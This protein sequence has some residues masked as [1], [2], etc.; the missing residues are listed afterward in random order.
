M[1]TVLMPIVNRKQSFK[2]ILEVF[3]GCE[4][5][6]KISLVILTEKNNKILEEITEDSPS[7]FPIFVDVFSVGTSEEAMISSAIKNLE[8]SECVLIR[9]AATTFSSYHINKLFEGVL[10][11]YDVVMLKPKKQANK[12]KRFFQNLSK[13]LF[14]FL[15]GYNYYDGDIGM[16]YFGEQAVDILKT[17]NLTILTK[18]NKWIALSIFYVETDLKPIVFKNKTPKNF[19]VSMLATS[20]V[21]VLTIFL[22][23]F[24]PKLVNLNL[25]FGFLIF[26]AISAEIIFLFYDV[27]RIFNHKKLGVISCEKTERI[28]RRE[29]WRITKN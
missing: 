17:T 18:L 4:H 20:V 8:T 6:D 2:E 15:F 19:V 14:K 7:N 29:V 22:A 5:S 9:D 16:Q 12:I 3:S 25:L 13:K 24:L 21:L 26:F 27:L 11:G 28:T 10:L 1:I 23:I